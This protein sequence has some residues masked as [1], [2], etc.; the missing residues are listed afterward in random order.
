MHTAC[1]AFSFHPERVA[2][3]QNGVEM[4]RHFVRDVRL[5]MRVEDGK[6]RRQTVADIRRQVGTAR[7]CVRYPGVTALLQRV[8]VHR[9]VGEQLTCVFVDHGLCAKMKAIRS[10]PP[11]P[12][13]WGST[14]AVSTHGPRFLQ[15]LHGVTDPEQSARSSATIHLGFPAR[16]AS[17]RCGGLSG[18][19]YDLSRCDRERY[20]Q[21]DVIRAITMWAACRKISASRGP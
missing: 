21:A 16:G 12:K 17:V 18:T 7:C 14:F 20:G 11:T 3:T 4:L 5:C 8:L 19:G 1:T 13:K 15:K 2:H 9:A 6:R 10:W